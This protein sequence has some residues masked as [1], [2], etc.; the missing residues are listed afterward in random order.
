M[1]IVQNKAITFSNSLGARTRITAD[2]LGELNML[3]D[4]TR[5][6]EPGINHVHKLFYDL[7]RTYLKENGFPLKD[8]HQYIVQVPIIIPF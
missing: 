7:C 6:K 1:Q 3:N 2:I 8:M 5:V 4:E